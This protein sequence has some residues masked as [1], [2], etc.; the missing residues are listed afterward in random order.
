M[1]II[2][3][4]N[5]SFQYEKVPVFAHLDMTISKGDFTALIGANGAGKST[6]LKIILGELK[7]ESGEVEI[8]GVEVSRCKDW[9]E[10][11]YVPQ[12]S[13]FSMQSFPATVEEI[14]L[15]NL[16]SQIGFMGFVKKRHKEKV[17]DSLRK[18]GLEG[19]EKR[20]IG[21][22]SGGQQ[23]RVML[24]RVLV[25]DPKVLI[26]DEPTAGVDVK[27]AKSLYELLFELNEQKGITILIVTHDLTR[28]AGYIQHVYCLG[29]GSLV[30]LDRGQVED[31]IKHRHK[32]PETS[33]GEECG[34]GHF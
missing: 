17:A 27:S 32:H 34:H 8:A 28:I 23:Q 2:E 22:L 14:I 7:A 13:I 10:I 5:V 15:A 33:C 1:P 29:E 3:L 12:N 9:R 21:E 16:C 6:L 19:F 24:A 25:N 30:Y 4:K 20:M 18:V 26:L 11:G 31:E